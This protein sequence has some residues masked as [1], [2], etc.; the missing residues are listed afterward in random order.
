MELNG[1]N[2]AILAV[3]LFGGAVTVY[4]L[5][6]LRKLLR[7]SCRRATL[8][9]L[10]D[11]ISLETLKKLSEVSNI[12]IRQ[13]ARDLLT[14]RVLKP[15]SLKF[16]IQLCYAENEESVMKACTVIESL[17]K[18]PKC[19]AKFVYFGGLEAL[20]HAIYRSWARK[21]KGDISNNYMK[22][23]NLC[24]I[25]IFDLIS[26]VDNDAPKIRLLDKNPSF[27]PTMLGI[28]K[29]T[30][31]RETEKLGLFIIHQIG[32]CEHTQDELSKHWVI[33]EVVSKVVVK[34]QGEPMKLRLAFQVLV[35]LANI[36]MA[37]EEQNVLNEIQS[38]GVIMPTIGCLKSGNGF[39]F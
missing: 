34:R 31:N 33:I 35:T 2:A 37:N 1:R 26:M 18:N 4:T 38:F 16:L 7:R 19:R 20:S 6:S 9:Q 8:A 30:N 23:Q 22:I 3:G 21:N 11:R 25:A 39:F 12:S 32:V 29:E 5:F 13:C 10:T 17:T 36:L 14:V 24:C 15:N 28:M 27:L